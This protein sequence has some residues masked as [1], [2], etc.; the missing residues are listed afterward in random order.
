[1]VTD[2]EKRRDA[3]IE[4]KE[5]L[6]RR[7]E[8]LRPLV[9]TLEVPALTRDVLTAVVDKIYWYDGVLEVLVKGEEFLCDD[10][11]ESLVNID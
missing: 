8:V 1:M 5:Y 4:R 10:E 11:P 6:E 2:M 7:R 9:R 3:E